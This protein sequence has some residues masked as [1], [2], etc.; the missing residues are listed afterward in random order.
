M[1]VEFSISVFPVLWLVSEELVSGKKEEKNSDITSDCWAKDM[2]EYMMLWLPLTLSKLEGVLLMVDCLEN[3][4]VETSRLT[5]ISVSG[6]QPHYTGRMSVFSQD[7]RKEFT[8][9]DSFQKGTLNFSS[10]SPF[11]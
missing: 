1:R 11:P 3:K 8:I 7:L 10:V 4:E 6:H 2:K 9:S 5:S